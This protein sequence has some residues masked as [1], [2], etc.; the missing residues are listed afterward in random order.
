MPTFVDIS[1]VRSFGLTV[2]E[3]QPSEPWT[4]ALKRLT[5]KIIL[6][7]YFALTVNTDKIGYS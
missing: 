5:G 1:L 3:N 6:V 4:P 2:P 7:L